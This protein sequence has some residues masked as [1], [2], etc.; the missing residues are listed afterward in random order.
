MLN[1]GLFG[2]VPSGGQQLKFK[3]ETELRKAAFDTAVYYSKVVREPLKKGMNN[4]HPAIAKFNKAAKVPATSPYCSTFGMY[5]FSSNG[6]LFPSINGMAY[7]WKQS[8]K[9]VWHR[10]LL[11]IDQRLWPKVSLMDAV[12]STWSHVEFAAPNEN[13]GNVGYLKYGITVVGG[14]TRGG[15]NRGEGVYYPIYRPFTL[16]SG[17]YNH[18]TPYWANLKK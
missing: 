5:C 17:I 18:V 11:G 1:I 4:K 2:L 6:V 9:L 3:T 8:K 7:S 10:G 16:I 12:V 15:V 14:N 13:G